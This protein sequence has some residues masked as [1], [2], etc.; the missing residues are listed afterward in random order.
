MKLF[1]SSRI[2]YTMTK[3][4]LLL[5]GLLRVLTSTILNRTI[6]YPLATK[7]VRCVRRYSILARTRSVIEFCDFSPF[8]SFPFLLEQNPPSLSFFFS[9]LNLFLSSTSIYTFQGSRFSG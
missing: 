9:F 4:G 5:Q 8:C 2:N 3:K 6:T 1:I 7:L